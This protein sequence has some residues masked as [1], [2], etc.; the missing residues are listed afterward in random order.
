MSEDD[1][2]GDEE[3]CFSIS[4]SHCGSVFD[5]NE[6]RREC[7]NRGG[8]RERKESEKMGLVE[9]EQLTNT[10]KWSCSRGDSLVACF[11]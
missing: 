9:R 8:E 10:N 1:D 7:L 11:L 6:E 3:E 2:E 5:G 4:E